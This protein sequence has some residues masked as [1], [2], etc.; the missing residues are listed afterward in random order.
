[1]LLLQQI[2]THIEVWLAGLIPYVVYILAATATVV[3]TIQSQV[4]NNVTIQPQTQST[5][6]NIPTVSNAPR[7]SSSGTTVQ[8]W[9]DN[10]NWPSGTHATVER[11]I[12]CESGGN[13]AAISPTGY[14]GLMQVAPWLH[15]P[16]PNDP[17]AQ[18]NDAYE[19]YL[20]QGWGAW[21][22]Y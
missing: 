2:L 13:P 8:Q 9:V 12:S 15:G 10:S 7:P 6:Y 5:P 14:T 1:M 17:V 20:K 4:S 3:P 16:V 22:C 18:L 21:S 11:I 19:V